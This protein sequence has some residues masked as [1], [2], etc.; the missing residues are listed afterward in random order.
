MVKDVNLLPEIA[1]KETK[2]N[3][4]KKFATLFSL[5]VLTSVF[6]LALGVFAYQVMKK[7]E[8]ED[9]NKMVESKAKDVQRHQATEAT[10]RAL[11]IKLTRLGQVFNSSADKEKI[12]QDLASLINPEIKITGLKLDGKNLTVIGTAASSLGWGEF[13]T[14][15][16]DKESVGKGFFREVVLKSFSKQVGKTGYSFDLVMVPVILRGD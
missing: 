14:N 2:V 12:L 13:L 6:L 16:I 5:L 1:E 15:L 11:D 4:R 7:N 3:E 9:V 10:V 8:L